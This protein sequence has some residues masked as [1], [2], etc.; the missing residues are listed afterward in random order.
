MCTSFFNEIPLSG[1]FCPVIPFA[2]VPLI[3]VKIS[4]LRK[5]VFV[6]PSMHISKLSSVQV[7]EWPPIG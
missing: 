4:L 2:H 5:G 1:V 3:G 7:T 6:K